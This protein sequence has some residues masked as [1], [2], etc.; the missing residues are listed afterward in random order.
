MLGIKNDGSKAMYGRR[1][2]KCG[3]RCRRKALLGDPYNNI[4]DYKEYYYGTTPSSPTVAPVTSE[5]SSGSWWSRQSPS[6]QS[7]IIGGIANLGGQLITSLGNGLASR[8]MQKANDYANNVLTGARNQVRDTYVDAYNRMHGIDADGLIN[9]DDFKV[10]HA[11]AN[12][13]AGRFNVN[14][15]LAQVERDSARQIR[16]VRGGMNNALARQRLMSDIATRSQDAR[17][18]IYGEQ[19]NQIEKINQSNI[20]QLNE[21]A[22]KNAEFDSR[23]KANLSALKVDVA[24]YNNDINNSKIQGIA[25]A[26]ANAITGNAQGDAQ[27]RI[28]NSGL[29]ANFAQSTLSGLGNVLAGT[30]K[31]WYDADQAYRMNQANIASSLAASTNP[32]GAALQVLVNP[33][34]YSTDNIRL[35]YMA[36][37]NTNTKNELAKILRSRGVTV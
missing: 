7:A 26:Q 27:T 36:T 35:A 25:D 32:N 8:Y 30:A 10:Q 22:M 28:N 29:R 16:S 24:K 5:P 15:Q 19:S 3:G 33:N 17:D 1:Y 37:D 2:M 4:N 14:P 31:Q 13:R 34:Y 20:A 12:V 23:S 21:V 6:T 9:E 18:K 11:I